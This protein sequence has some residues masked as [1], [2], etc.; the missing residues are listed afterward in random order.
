[1]NRPYVKIMLMAKNKRR[2]KEYFEDE[3]VV[4][5]P[6]TELFA[7]LSKAETTQHASVITMDDEKFFTPDFRLILKSFFA[8][9]ILALILTSATIWMVDYRK[10][11]AFSTLKGE[12]VKTETSA[13]PAS[14]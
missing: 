1:M 14:E 8:Y 13:E 11:S 4:S 3:T 12:V 10:D 6:E 9:S 7:D 2:E 5:A